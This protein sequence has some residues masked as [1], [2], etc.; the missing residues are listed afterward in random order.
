MQ[1]ECAATCTSGSG[2]GGGGGDGRVSARDNGFSAH[3]RVPRGADT[4]TIAGHA[5]AH[6]HL[7]HD[8]A[9]RRTQQTNVACIARGSGERHEVGARCTATRAARADA[10][11]AY[12]VTITSSRTQMPVAGKLPCTRV[13]S[14]VGHVT[15]RGPPYP[16]GLNAHS[17]AP[18]APL[19]TITAPLSA[20]TLV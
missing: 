10:P 1:R 14:R 19:Y 11:D 13:R 17:R 3:D 5:V 2:G 15:P 6:T 8:A 18:L 16:V 12:D 4:G 7:H 20:P 9:S